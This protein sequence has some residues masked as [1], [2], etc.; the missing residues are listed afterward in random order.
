MRPSG[1]DKDHPRTIRTKT[2]PDQGRRGLQRGECL[3]LA[4]LAL[5]MAGGW[6]LA[7]HG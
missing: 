2:A 5:V 7:L 6:L 4:L 1:P 3:D